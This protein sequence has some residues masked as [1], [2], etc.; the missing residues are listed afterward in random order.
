MRKK[1]IAGEQLDLIDVAPENAKPIVEAARLY[2]E[3]QSARLNA[4][5]EE[6]KQRDEVLKL[7]KAAKLQPLEGGKIKF[8]Y[9][10]FTISVTPRNELITVKEAKNKSKVEKKT[11]MKKKVEAEEKQ[12]DEKSKK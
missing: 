5:K 12:F 11:S 7:I 8:T 6:L 10:G 9:G 2:K 1:K 4:L 3:A